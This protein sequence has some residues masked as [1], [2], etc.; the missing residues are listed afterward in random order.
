[1][2]KIALL[3]NMAAERAA[4][5]AKVR[6]RFNRLALENLHDDLVRCATGG[7]TALIE[8]NDRKKTILA[9]IAAAQTPAEI[10]AALS[11]L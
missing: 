5:I 10:E 7:A 9:L 4:A 11:S 2:T 3:P 8:R 6:D 1:M